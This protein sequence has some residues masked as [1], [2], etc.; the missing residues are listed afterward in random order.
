MEVMGVRSRRVAP[1]HPW[2]QLPRG[3]GQLGPDLGA[4]S[5]TKEPPAPWGARW[6]L[7]GERGVLGARGGG[8][9]WVMAPPY[10]LLLL[11]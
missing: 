5:R 4:G 3:R 8:S 9:P 10:V 2:G 7:D 11:L 6:L 1:P